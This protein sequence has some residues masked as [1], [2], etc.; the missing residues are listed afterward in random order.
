MAGGVIVAPACIA[1]SEHVAKLFGIT[2][3]SYTKSRYFASWEDGMM[4]EKELEYMDEP[5]EK[6]FSLGTKG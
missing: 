4:M 6:D 1:S 3:A 5:E 2:A